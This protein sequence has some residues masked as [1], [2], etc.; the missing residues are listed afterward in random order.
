MKSPV[1][2]GRGRFGAST[3][4][5]VEGRGDIVARHNLIS[6]VVRHEGRH[7]VWTAAIRLRIDFVQTPVD[8][9]IRV[10]FV[11]LLPLSDALRQ[12]VAQNKVRYSDGIITGS[13]HHGDCLDVLEQFSNPVMILAFLQR[14]KRFAEGK[15]A[16]DVHGEKRHPIGHVDEST[17]LPILENHFLKL[18]NQEITV[19]LNERMGGFE[20]AF[21]EGVA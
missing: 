5:E 12:Q 17:P 13:R 10:A 3:D 18:L 21:G 14:V 20:G 11:R 19:S 16:N 9:I 7:E 4:N 6:G 8:P 15:I 2:R 1:Q